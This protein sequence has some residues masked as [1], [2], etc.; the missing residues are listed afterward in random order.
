[1][2]SGSRQ[3]LKDVSRQVLLVMGSCK[4]MLKTQQ[5]SE[6][7][8]HVSVM[9]TWSS[10][11]TPPIVIKGWIGFFNKELLCTGCCAKNISTTNAQEV[12]KQ[13]QKQQHGAEVTAW[14][15]PTGTTCM[16]LSHPSKAGRHFG[17]FMIHQPLTSD[18]GSSSTG[19]K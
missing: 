5:V 18:V 3:A 7:S 6:L 19:L 9:A 1:M 14:L 13:Q 10:V 8:A 4:G 17:S 12:C 16:I 15:Y 11:R 2:Y